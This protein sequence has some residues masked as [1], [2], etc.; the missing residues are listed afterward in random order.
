MQVVDTDICTDIMLKDSNVKETIQLCKY[1]SIAHK[2]TSCNAFTQKRNTGIEWS[3]RNS[4]GEAY[5]SKQYLKF[6]A[7]ALELKHHST[8]FYDTYIRG[9]IYDKF[10]IN[11]LELKQPLRIKHTG[12]LTTL[13]YQH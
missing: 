8:L 7:K 5:T 9:S 11:C 2:E 3:S 4:V 12:K 1:L 6:Y 10:D 13:K